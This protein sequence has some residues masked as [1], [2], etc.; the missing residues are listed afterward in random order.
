MNNIW[1]ARF[2]C[3]YASNTLPVEL[4]KHNVSLELHLAQDKSQLS[5][6]RHMPTAECGEAS[7]LVFR[8]VERTS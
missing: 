6:C 5:N 2:G 7:L 1:L 8:G 3:Q 4:R